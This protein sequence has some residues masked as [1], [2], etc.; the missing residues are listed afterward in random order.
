MTSRLRTGKSVTF[1]DSVEH[2]TLLENT[3]LMI[4]GYTTLLENIIQK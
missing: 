1:F 4:T 3:I 2:C